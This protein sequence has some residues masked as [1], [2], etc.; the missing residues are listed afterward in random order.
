MAEEEKELENVSEEKEIH[1]TLLAG[2]GALFVKS[3]L[4]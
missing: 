3:V 4:L 1:I 2:G